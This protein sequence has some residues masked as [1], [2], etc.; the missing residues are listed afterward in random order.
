[1]DF[2]SVASS[3]PFAHGQISWIPLFYCLVLSLSTSLRNLGVCVTLLV[4]RFFVCL[5]V[6]LFTHSFVFSYVCFFNLITFC[7]HVCFLFPFFAVCYFS[8]C[9]CIFFVFFVSFLLTIC[10]FLVSFYNCFLVF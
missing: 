1:M 4:I 2:Y 6:C 5:F 7:L 8:V 3:R 9:M 10:L